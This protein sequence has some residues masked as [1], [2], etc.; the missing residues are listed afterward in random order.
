MRIRV[1]WGLYW[2]PPIQEGT[3][4]TWKLILL[5]KKTRPNVKIFQKDPEAAWYSQK[6]NGS[7]SDMLL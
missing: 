4:S 3:E 7:T 6:W 2:D 5:D 1:F